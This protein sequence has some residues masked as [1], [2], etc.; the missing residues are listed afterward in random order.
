MKILQDILAVVVFDE[1]VP[2]ERQ[3]GRR[4]RHRQEDANQNRAASVISTV[5]QG[6][7]ILPNRRLGSTQKAG[8]TRLTLRAEDFPA[9]PIPVWHI[10]AHKCSVPLSLGTPHLC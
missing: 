9:T 7:P 10:N 2:K 5:H 8:R 3:V 1:T 6:C 4:R